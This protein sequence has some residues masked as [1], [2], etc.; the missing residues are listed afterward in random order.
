MRTKLNKNGYVA[1]ISIITL[2][3]GTLAMN[4]Q[5]LLGAQSY[6][7]FVDRKVVRIQN[8]LNLSACLDMGI[9]MLASDFWVRGVKNL[10]DLNC[11]INFIEIDSNTIQIIA[12]S[13]LSFFGDNIKASG[14]ENIRLGDKELYKL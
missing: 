5:V 9:Y 10:P 3:L 13:S 8:S 6:S 12:T 11:V 7:D 2:A 1:L 4:I 14:T